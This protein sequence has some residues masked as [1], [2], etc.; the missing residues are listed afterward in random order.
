MN[1]EDTVCTILGCSNGLRFLEEGTD[2]KLIAISLPSDLKSECLRHLW[3]WGRQPW[4]W[5]KVRQEALLYGDA[6][7][8]VGPPWGLNGPT[9]PGVS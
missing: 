5:I 1:V 3:E 2:Y 7:A 6:T 4:A 8:E 9:G